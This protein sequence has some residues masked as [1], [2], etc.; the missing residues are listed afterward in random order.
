MVTASSIQAVGSKRVSKHAIPI[1][2][3]QPVLLA[4]TSIDTNVGSL[5]HG[6][7]NVW[8]GFKMVVSFCS[9]ASPKDSLLRR[10]RRTVVFILTEC[11]SA[12]V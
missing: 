6:G 1:V 12:L 10:E 2:F 3:T 9:I 7:V 5:R 11:C 8:S 4:P